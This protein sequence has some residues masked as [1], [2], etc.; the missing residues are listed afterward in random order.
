MC[1]KA[2]PY[3]VD[4]EVGRSFREPQY[5]FSHSRI[6]ASSLLAKIKPP[7]TIKQHFCLPARARG[8]LRMRSRCRD[9]SRQVKENCRGMLVSRHGLAERNIA[10]IL[11]RIRE[12]VVRRVARFP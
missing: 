5:D 4:F 6:Y 11:Q 12:R 1:Y 10:Q 9:S 3:L 8:V 7:R 2:L